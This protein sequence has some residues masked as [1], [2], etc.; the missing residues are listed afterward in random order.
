[1]LSGASIIIKLHSIS[2]CIIFNHE[3]LYGVYLNDQM[4]SSKG[5]LLIGS[6]I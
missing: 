2:T 3:I 4:L 6:M 5:P 1:M